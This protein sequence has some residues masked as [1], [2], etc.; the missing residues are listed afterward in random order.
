MLANLAGYHYTARKHFDYGIRHG[1]Q[2]ICFVDLRAKTLFNLG[3]TDE[4]IE[5]FAQT[6]RIFPGDK[7]LC[8]GST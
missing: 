1:P 5:A 2:G 8:S 7:C 6:V 4:A 3:P